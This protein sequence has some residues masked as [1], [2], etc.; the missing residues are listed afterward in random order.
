[1]QVQQ[2]KEGSAHVYSNG[3]GVKQCTLCYQQDPSGSGGPVQV[4]VSEASPA[5]QQAHRHVE[6]GK[7]R[8][9]RDLV[10]VGGAR[11]KIYIFLYKENIC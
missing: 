2:V 10:L 5:T 3:I 8:R 7:R 11:L 6:E 1:M 9:P 4:V